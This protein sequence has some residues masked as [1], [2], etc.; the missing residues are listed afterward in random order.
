LTVA[1]Y[2]ILAIASK[3]RRTTI[4][5]VVLEAWRDLIHKAILLLAIRYDF[6]VKVQKSAG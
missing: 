5:K 1:E 4:R 3:E 6:Q 2:V